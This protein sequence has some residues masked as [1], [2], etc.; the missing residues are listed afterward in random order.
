MNRYFTKR[1]A[2]K[3]P[4]SEPKFEL[5]LT[6]A[7][8]AQDD[9][10]TSLIMNSLSARFSMLREQDDPS[11]LLGKASDDSVL[12]PR[13]QSRLMDFGYSPGRT[14]HDIAEVSS[15]RSSIRPPFAASNRADSY[16]SEG[17]YGTDDDSTYNGSM[18]NRARQGEGNSLFGGRQKIY[19]IPM[20]GA[21]SE[22]SIASGGSMK[23]RILYDDDVSMSTF[24]RW[25]QEERERLGKDKDGSHLM[26]DDESSS[27][28]GQQSPSLSGT[29]TRHASTS[30]NAASIGRTSTAATSINSQHGGIGA[31]TM[32]SASAASPPLG[33]G[34]PALDRNLSKS[35]RLYDQILNRDIEEQQSSALT[36]LNS[37]QKSKTVSPPQTFG[38]SNSRQGASSYRSPSP[39]QTSPPNNHF[40]LPAF[41]L[42]E[43]PIPENDVS[44]PSPPRKTNHNPL[45]SALNPQDRGKATAM[46]AFNKPQQFSEQQYLERQLTLRG[47]QRPQLAAAEEEPMEQSRTV[48]VDED[49]SVSP[50]IYAT[51]NYSG[52]SRAATNASAQDVNFS[53]FSVF[54]QAA[55]K[56]KSAN[57]AESDR[58][59]MEENNHGFN[60][61]LNHSEDDIPPFA[62]MSQFVIPPLNM[63]ST[64]LSAE[65]ERGGHPAFKDTM[66]PQLEPLSAFEPHFNDLQPRNDI[67]PAIYASSKAEE[68]VQSLQSLA[69]ANG[70]LSG[71]VRQHLRQHSA[72]S[73]QYDIEQDDRPP[74][75]HFPG[76]L[77]LSTKDVSGNNNHKSHDLATPA[78]S[79][80]SHASNPFDLEDLKTSVNAENGRNSPVNTHYD[81]PQDKKPEESV[82]P[83]EARATRRRG[84]SQA[85]DTIHDIPWAQQLHKSHN[86]GPSAETIQ[87][88]DAF[89]S[90]LARRKAAIQERLKVKM[91][92]ESASPS[93]VQEDKFMGGPFRGFDMLRTKSS[94]ESMKRPTDSTASNKQSKL[95]GLPSS[96]TPSVNER[97][98]FQTDRFRSEESTSTYTPSLRS[99]STSRPATSRSVAPPPKSYAITNGGE[100]NRTSDDYARDRKNSNPP[101]ISALNSNTRSRSNSV[102]SNGRSRSRNG[103]YKDDLEKAM[104]EGTSS[105]VTTQIWPDGPVIPEDYAPPLPSLDKFENTQ[106]F[107]TDASSSNPHLKIST[108][109]PSMPANGY[110]ESKG[111]YPPQSMNSPMSASSV[112]SSPLFPAQGHHSMSTGGFSPRP[113]PGFSQM[114]PMSSAR[115]SPGGYHN[116]ATPP[117]SGASTPIS[118]SFSQYQHNQHPPPQAADNRARSLSKKRS[119]QKHEIGEPRLISTTSVIDTVSLPT[120]ASLR[121]GMS[122]IQKSVPPVPAV[123]PLRQRFGFNGNTPSQTGMNSPY[124]NHEGSSFKPRH[125]LRKSSS[126]G[127]KL[128]MRLRAQSQATAS[129]PALAQR[130][131]RPPIEGGM[132]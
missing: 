60:F 116:M 83:K 56:I 71:L 23:G 31:N 102:Q 65:P 64:S 106:R 5:D 99:R 82:S 98:S 107:T 111:L 100:S 32:S 88:Q 3:A 38:R 114:S 93:P 108:S 92:N 101:P 4:A 37:L 90:E 95:F 131:T 86:R 17:G 35:R 81:E 75:P 46:G 6:T 127:E 26:A 52:R 22:A 130:N 53:A 2:K 25:R 72:A 118:N 69:P 80:Y 16:I 97:P 58:P 45:I 49:R 1:K 76:Q 29:V 9:F 78:E 125:R 19:K 30:T 8:P 89:A 110:F 115:P 11:S 61:G 18:M 41:P 129:N 44:P 132:F 66:F 112:A 124:S 27:K 57:Q 126:E 84:M 42:T 128:G 24:Q 122:D 14:L 63:S 73:S 121:N 109:R 43:A 7:L 96:M 87:E 119:V 105:R 55:N 13:R 10:R 59:S 123:N 12:A 77:A 117:L 47:A 70:G 15:I 85:P 67:T 39:S 54:Q 34:S 51:S 40:G 94:R 28:F 104:V 68:P 113:S 79:S 91:E 120:G 36:R 74:I 62:D 50:S 21:T 33:S 103:R 20:A 48:S